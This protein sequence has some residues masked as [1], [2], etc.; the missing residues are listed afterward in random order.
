MKKIIILF[1][2]IFLI[3]F[4]NLKNI[5]AQESNN[6]QQQE[7]IPKAYQCPPELDQIYAQKNTGEKCTTNYQEYKNDPMRYHYWTDDHQITIE[8]RAKERARQF[9]FW[10]MTHPS[11]DNHPTLIK[12]WSS[13]RN[14]SYFLTIL[15]ASLL[16]LGIIIGQKTNFDTGVKIWPSIIKILMSLFY[17]TFSATIVITIIQLS[18][19]L[20][21]FFIE[22]LGGKDLFNTYFNS[23]SQENNYNFYGIKDL[24]LAAQ[25]AV[26]NQLFI[27][28][29]TEITY[30]LLGIMIILRKIILWFLLFVSPFLAILLSFNLLKNTAIIWI[31]VFFQWVFYGP[32]LALFLGATSTIWKN[33][34]PFIFDFSRSETVMGYVYPT[35][36]NILWGGPSQKLSILNN[37]NYVDPYAEYI[38]TLIML[39]A[40]I[41]F[42]WWLLRTFRDYCCDGINA[43]KNILMSNFNN[44]YNPPTP[45]ISPSQFSSFSTIK[46]VRKEQIK[47]IETIEEIKKAKT[48][49]IISSLNIKASNLADIARFETN[50]EGLKNLNY[51]KNP[52]QATTISDRQKYINIRVEL[53]NRAS[54]KDQLAGKIINSVFS[55]PNQQIQNK[56]ALINSLPKT[57]TINQVVSYNVKLPITKIQ[58]IS[59]ST[60]NYINLNTKIVSQL[61]NNLK[62]KE[63]IIK[64]VLDILNQNFE[65]KP[66]EILEKINQETK[67]EKEQIKKIIKE[68]ILLIK[69]DDKTIEQ[70]AN[71]TNV[72]PEEVKQVVE[73]QAPIIAEPEKNIEKI[74]IPQTINIDEYEQVKRMWQQQYEKGEIPVNENIKTREQWV[75]NDV[76]VITNTLN[77]LY[78]DNETVK[79]QGLDEVGYI[80][81]IFMIN[82]LNGEQL[83]VYLKAKLEAAKA[84]K[85]LLEKEKEIAEK[86]K[87]ETEKVEIKKPAKAQA[88]KIMEMK[89]EIN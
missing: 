33:G 28:K 43:I 65:K 13:A 57:S 4:F 12:I 70:I 56:I 37:I 47:K 2:L 48:E 22:N 68:Y 73:T 61:S 5:N 86:L 54:Q 75:E 84:I 62:I 81:P 88:E 8:G 3:L 80:L 59:S 39:L 35:A 71:Q 21:K 52:T 38:I 34:I 25:E 6:N 85:T 49:E 82:N 58:Q 77:K 16:G 76:V 24:N 44:L 66:T 72:K 89:Q 7:I 50:K 11:I 87:K 32:L 14:L 78:S 67:L 74:I 60:I 26:K 64:Q 1:F 40:T 36:T 17:I 20:M 31:N 79:Q 55:R 83:V 69:S 30:Y 23:A 10:V 19:I 42:P 15:I 27:L 29:L 51:L 18:D 46:E 63:E 53:S 45:S 41:F 9:I